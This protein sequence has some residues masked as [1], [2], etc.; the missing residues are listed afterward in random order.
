[1]PGKEEGKTCI[2]QAEKA[3]CVKAR[4]KRQYGPFDDVLE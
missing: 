1:M 4:G 2:F 3:T